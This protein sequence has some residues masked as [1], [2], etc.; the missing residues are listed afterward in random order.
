MKKA[1]V[2]VSFGTTH[3][4]TLQ[5]TIEAIEGRLIQAFPDRDF[6]RAW[7]ALMVINKL[8]RRDGIHIPTT[9]EV[10]QRLADAGY[11][12]VLIQSTH[13]TPGV[14]FLRVQ[15]AIRAFQGRFAR[16][17]LG[18]PLIYFQGGES[19]GREMPDDYEPV[20]AAYDAMLPATSPEHAVVLFGHGTAHPANAIY[21]ALQCRFRDRGQNVLVGTVDAYPELDDVRRQLRGT[22]VRRVTLVPMM[23]VAGDHVKNDM[24]GEEADSWRRVLEADGYDV[25]VVLKGLGEMSAFQEIFVQH[26]REASEFPIWFD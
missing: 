1:L 9:K 11:Q 17:A 7:T 14:E 15:A 20:L 24:A 19:R 12:D 4:D 18:R 22:P 6:F 23:V 8:K 21:A 5:K 10:L 2:V 25:D 13:V 3:F 16:V 26:A